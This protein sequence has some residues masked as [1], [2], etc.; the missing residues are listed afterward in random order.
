MD[1]GCVDIGGL[2]LEP[3]QSTAR[4]PFG[5]SAGAGA[6]APPAPRRLVD[7]AAK[8]LPEL[9]DDDGVVWKLTYG[10]RVMTYVDAAGVVDRIRS[11][12]EA[13]LRAAVNRRR[14]N[15]PAPLLVSGLIKVGALACSLSFEFVVATHSCT[16]DQ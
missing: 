6:D 8:L 4:P 2:E 7:S 15:A 13:A 14:A 12:A 3:P 16:P 10:D 1:I 5:D 9:S 11:W